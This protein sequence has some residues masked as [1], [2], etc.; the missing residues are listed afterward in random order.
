M[1]QLSWC[2]WLFPRAP[3][4]ELEATAIQARADQGDVEAQFA[5]GLKYSIAG[6]ELQDLVRS[7][8]WYRKASEQNHPL[9]Q[10]NLGLMCAK[11]EGVP[12]DDAQAFMWMRKAAHQGD[13]G[14]QFNLG[15]RYHRASVWG[16]QLDAFEPK[17]EAYKWLQLAAAQGYRSS[18]EACER[19][20]LG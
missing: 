3:E 4:P 8:E 2:Q 1:D 14:A 16:V 11:G 7:A 17:I 19:V 15:M 18:A 13:A 6:G 5:L 20:T 10:F 9:A 12:Q